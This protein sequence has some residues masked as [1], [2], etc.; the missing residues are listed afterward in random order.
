MIQR[1]VDDAMTRHERMV[2]QCKQILAG[3]TPEQIAEKIR[4][5]VRAEIERGHE[6]VLPERARPQR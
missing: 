2:K 6:M 4:E 5:D 3:R 1:N